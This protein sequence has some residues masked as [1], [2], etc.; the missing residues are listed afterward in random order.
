MQDKTV[1]HASRR[2]SAGRE[3]NRGSRP[4]GET[5]RSAQRHANRHRCVSGDDRARPRRRGADRQLELGFQT[6]GGARPGAG[7][8]PN[9]SRAGVTHAR[10]PAHA[11]RFPVL[12][13]S[14][15]RT[16]LGS[17]RR[18]REL[19]LIRAALLEAGARGDF[20]VVHHSIQSN[21]VHL[22]LEARSREALTG[23][24]RGL[25]VRLARGLN[26][27][28]SRRGSVF[29]DRFHARALQTP[30]EVRHALVYVLQNARKHGIGLQ[31]P[32]ACSSGPWFDGW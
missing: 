6:R 21:H 30:R 4:A 3:R 10:R 25:M 8:K 29:A 31:G 27:L 22:I 7:R 26:R 17:L 9:G 5:A 18:P 28:W 19:A 2:S 32:D 13:T 11:A 24:M 15:L 23:G 12:V 14:R 16:G 1:G 20:Q